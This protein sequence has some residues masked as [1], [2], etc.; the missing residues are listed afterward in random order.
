MALVLTSI[1]YPLFRWVRLALRVNKQSC[2]CVGERF[3]PVRSLALN[4]GGS[5]CESHGRSLDIFVGDKVSCDRTAV[6]LYAGRVFGLDAQKVLNFFHFASA[7][8]VSFAR[9]L[10]DTPKMVAL[11]VAAGAL[12]LGLSW[13]IFLV[14]VVMGAGGFF[15]AKKVAYTMSHRI[16]RM[17]HG[18]GFTANLITSI[19]VIF[20]SRWGL[21]VS[22]THVS[23]G[24]LFG[25]GMVTGKA[26]WK[27]I[28]G[29]VSAWVLTLPL[30]AVL[31]GTVFWVL[32]T[33]MVKV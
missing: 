6:E 2:V 3:V 23:C 1:I 5:L 7:G 20:A 29:I 8:A 22:T 32:N 13:N 15:S 11:S 12:E 14:G 21:P 27:M 25:I 24:S 16:T 28:G 4:T 9:G 30:A 31:A 17:N 18:Q 26:R 10:N 19:L 33:F